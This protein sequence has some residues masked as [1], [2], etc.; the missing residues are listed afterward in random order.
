MKNK[1]DVTSIIQVLGGTKDPI[2]AMRRFTEQHESQSYNDL[3]MN[4]LAKVFS[5]F[6]NELDSVKLSGKNRKRDLGE[7][8]VKHFEGEI[9]E[10]Q[11]N[12]PFD[13][14]MRIE[15]DAVIYYKF[16]FTKGKS[17]TLKREIVDLIFI[18]YLI[19]S[20]SIKTFEN[21]L[22]RWGA[23]VEELFSEP[24]T[25]KLHIRQMQ[26]RF[27]GKDIKARRMSKQEKESILEKRNK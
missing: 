16:Y 26:N 6:L 7:L 20:F 17:A 3:D 15:I 18:K 9:K 1:E 23:H 22:S 13:V 25:K 27:K 10:H 5:G 8:F 21:W 19:P 24:K 4:T 11:N 12:V 14:R 2:G